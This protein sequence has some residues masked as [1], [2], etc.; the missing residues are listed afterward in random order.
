MSQVVSKADYA[1]LK[2]VSA[3]R[4]SQWISAGQIER[5]AL[6]GEGRGAKIDVALADEQLRRKL[7]IGQRVGNGLS[8]RLGG[9]PADKTGSRARR[10]AAVRAC[11][12]TCGSGAIGDRQV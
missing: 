2:S 6:V 5:S 11:R 7:D 3:A 8:T 12:A 4:V 9:S 1:R 10:G